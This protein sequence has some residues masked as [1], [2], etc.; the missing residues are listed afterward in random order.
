MHQVRGKR[1][2]VD[3][4]AFDVQ[5]E[6]LALQRTAVAELQREVELHA[7]VRHRA[8]PWLKATL[9]RIREPAS[10]IV[11]VSGSSSSHQAQATPNSGTR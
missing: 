7:P 5:A 1:I 9:P 2:V 6:T 3:V 4:V 8:R 11:Q 10:A